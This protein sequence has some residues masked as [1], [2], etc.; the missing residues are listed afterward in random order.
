MAGSK[1]AV[2][3]SKS[4]VSHFLSRGF[5]SAS[6]RNIGVVMDANG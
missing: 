5:G 1:G 6:I 2:K 4:S 3:A